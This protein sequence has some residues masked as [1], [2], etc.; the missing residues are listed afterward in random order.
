M[1]IDHTHTANGKWMTDSQVLAEVESGIHNASD[2]ILPA[3]T[4]LYRA[5]HRFRLDKATG[6]TVPNTP[7][8]VYESPWWS[9]Y[10][11]FNKVTWARGGDDQA[12]A[13]RSAYAIHPGWGGDCTLFASIVLTCD[14]SVWYGIGKAVTEAELGSRQMS[15]WFPDEDILQIYIPGLHRTGNAAQAGNAKLWTTQRS[16]F[17]VGG[18]FSNGTGYQGALPLPLTTAGGAGSNPPIQMTLF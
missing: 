13:A 12:G 1:P 4:C 14:L 6:Q 2:A 11:D 5:G 10:Y 8:A 16:V 3:E 18:A 17:N 9:T 15:V 7:E